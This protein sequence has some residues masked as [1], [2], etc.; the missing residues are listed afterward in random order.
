[1]Y[2]LGILCIIVALFFGGCAAT[3]AQLFDGMG[4]YRRPAGA[5]SEL[6]QRYFDQGL[7]L[8]YGFNHNE[9]ARSF[10]E[11]TRL[12]PDYQPAHGSR[13]SLARS[14]RRTCPTRV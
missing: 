10:K 2:L 8:T 12:D 5:R 6:A 7:I 9:A 1:M 3:D 4:T 11:A 13:V 14:R